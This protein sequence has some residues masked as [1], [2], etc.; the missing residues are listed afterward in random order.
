M[1]HH[2]HQLDVRVAHLAHVGHERVGQ[3]AVAQEPVA[4]LGNAT[5]RAEVH[6]VDRHRA[7]APAVERRAIAHPVVVAPLVSLVERRPMRVFGGISK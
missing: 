7:L 2:R 5:P 3:L 4:L 6:L 1:L